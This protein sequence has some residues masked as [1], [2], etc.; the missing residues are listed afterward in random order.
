[1]M[2]EGQHSNLS[3]FWSGLS[4]HVVGH[5]NSKR[6]LQLVIE[7]RLLAQTMTMG[8]SHGEAVDQHGKDLNEIQKIILWSRYDSYR[9]L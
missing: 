3:S 7:N 1:M 9:E 8:T 6:K 4:K 2:L 5:R